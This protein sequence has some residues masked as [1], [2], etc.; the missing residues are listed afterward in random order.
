MKNGFEKRRHL[1]VPLALQAVLMTPQGP[2]KGKTADISASGL[3]VILFIEKHEIGDKFEIALKSS[4]GHDMIVA[5]KMVW[6]GK[7]ISNEATY[8]AIGVKFTK[9]SSNDRELLA[10]LVEIYYLI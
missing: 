4:E 8:N 10:S 6:L 2:I 7:I 1:R 9:I 3:A 5:C